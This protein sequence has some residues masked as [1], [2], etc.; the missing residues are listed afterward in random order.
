[1][2]DP[3]IKLIG[4]PFSKANIYMYVTGTKMGLENKTMK[5]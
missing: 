3:Y 4:D 2:W 1:M 5:F